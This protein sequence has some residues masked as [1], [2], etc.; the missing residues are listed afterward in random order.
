MTKKD[1]AIKEDNAVVEADFLAELTQDAEQYKEALSQDDMAMP[2]LTLLQAMSPVC[3]EGDPA[4]KEGSRPGMAYDT[5]DGSMFDIKKEPLIFVAVAYKSSY[6]E[7]VPRSS[8]QGGFVKEHS[9]ALGMQAVVVRNDDNE[10]IIQPTSPVGQPG[11]Q[12]TFT[13]THFILVK[14]PDTGTFNPYLL[15]MQISQLKHSKKFNRMVNN[16]KV[17]GTIKPAPRFFGVWEISSQLETKGDN[18]WQSWAFKK[19]GDVT[20]IEDGMAIYK[21]AKDFSDSLNLEEV[22]IDYSKAAAVDDNPTVTDDIA[23]SDEDCEIPF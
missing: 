21:A 12:L 11:N 2:F 7:W 5:T 6:I 14:D 17:P 20:T 18:K 8:G 16:L 13:H 23:D 4:Y 15:T 10:D 22:A 1:V 3:T 19:H 9:T